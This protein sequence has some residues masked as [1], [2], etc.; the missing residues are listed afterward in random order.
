MI[1]IA[2]RE[3]DSST[4]DVIDWINHHN[5]QVLRVDEANQVEH[6]HIT[7]S[8][9]AHHS[10]FIQVNG[11]KVYFKDIAA[12]W[13]RKGQAFFTNHPA[14]SLKLDSSHVDVSAAVTQEW[15]IVKEYLFFL[16]SQNRHLGNYFQSS[17]NK[18]IVQHQAQSIGLLAPKATVLTAKEDALKIDFAAITKALSEVSIISF[19]DANFCS[20]TT[21]VTQEYIQTLP[22]DFFPALLQQKIE[23]KY[24]VRVF[25]LDGKCYSMAIFSQ[26]DQQTQVDFRVYN[27]TKP[28]RTV[29][30]QLPKELEAKIDTLMQKLQLNT[31][32]LD[33]MVTEDNQFYFLEVNPVG[34]F[35]MVSVPC[36]YYLEQKIADYLLQ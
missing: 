36:N 32:S 12:F 5:E 8:T 19:D 28:N 27:M 35:G 18:L 31:G 23:K 29:P 16:L 20:Y 24:E 25:Y 26:L 7:S 21:E 33:F 30:Y 14:Y 3:G 13:H 1:V 34:Q 4:N 6:L 2:T 9:D 11:Q 15:E 22:D 10:S 17:L